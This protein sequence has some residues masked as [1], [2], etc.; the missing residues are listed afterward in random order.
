MRSGLALATTGIAGLCLALALINAGLAYGNRAAQT[1]LQARADFVGQTPQVVRAGQIVVSALAEAA[2]RENDP[3][4][5]G[6]LTSNGITLRPAAD[7]A[8]AP[9]PAAPAAPAGAPR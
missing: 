4:V 1:E 7:A 3:A 6:L 5:R 2:A 9:A 8:A